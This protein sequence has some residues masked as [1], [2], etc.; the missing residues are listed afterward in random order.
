ML[1]EAEVPS[2][3]SVAPAAAS[4]CLGMWGTVGLR[5]KRGEYGDRLVNKINCNV[6]CN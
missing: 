3:V 2:F 5:A 6:K 1:L 4:F